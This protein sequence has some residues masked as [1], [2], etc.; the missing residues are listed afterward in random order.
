MKKKNKMWGSRFSENTMDLLT[1][2]NSS[3]NI[4]KRLA[5]VDITGSKAHVEMLANSDIITKKIKT[6]LLNGLNRIEKEI[7][8]DNFS[9]D[10]TLEDIHMNIE[11]RLGDII[12]LDAGHIHTARSRNDQVVTDFR[13][14]IESQS[15][16]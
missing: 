11:S 4:D 12:G 16:K 6:K 3:I 1:K 9:F 15:K 7:I 10:E 8:N 2:I 14:W 13:L 5:L